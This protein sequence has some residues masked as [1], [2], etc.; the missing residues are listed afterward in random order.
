MLIGIEIDDQLMNEALKATGLKSPKEVIELG[1]KKLVI[2][3]RQA[4]I[5]WF[6]GKLKWDD[7]VDSNKK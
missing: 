6:R 1:L 7:V 5:K 2:L 3:N 4:E